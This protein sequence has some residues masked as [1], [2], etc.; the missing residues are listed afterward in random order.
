MARVLVL[1]YSTYGHIETMANAVA[2]GARSAG[3]VVDVKRVP[4]TVP[5]EIAENG[6]FK[7]DQAAP[8]ATVE[9]LERYD[10]IVIGTGTRYG[11]M[12][13]QMASFL[14]QT[15]GLWLRGALN[16]KVGAAFVSTATQHGGQ[17]TTLFS[18]IT[19]LMHLGMVIVG[20]PYSHQGQMTLS[21][22]VGGAPYGA[23]TIAGGD[24]SRQPSEIDLEGARHQGKLVAQTAA[25]LFV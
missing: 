8:V 4:E 25:K 7:L 6:H 3:A 16:G 20:L 18:L 12:S 5:R 21:E 22:V 10:A 14:D 9:E 2:E 1:Y 24:G 13:S 15:G 11:R 19:N 23:T 17:E